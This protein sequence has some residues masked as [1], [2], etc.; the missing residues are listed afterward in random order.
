MNILDIC[1]DGVKHIYN[2]IYPDPYI[3]IA[4]TFANLLQ[5]RTPGNTEKCIQHIDQYPKYYNSY[6]KNEY[7]EYNPVIVACI[8]NNID[9]VTKLLGKKI[10]LNAKSTFSGRAALH[11][12]CQDLYTDIAL[13]LIR[14]G[15]D[16]NITDS[17]DS[18]PLHYSCQV[19][20]EYIAIELIQHGADVNMVNQARYTPFEIACRN[21][22]E[23]LAIYMM[24]HGAKFYDYIDNPDINKCTKVQQYIYDKYRA[25]LISVINDVNDNPLKLSFQTTYAIGIIDIIC[26]FIISVKKLKN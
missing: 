16:V 6:Y 25:G 11:I 19:A 1:I 22:V 4:Q 10:F 23:S 17:Y 7:T 24:D 2:K 14:A 12:A 21:N 18:T 8:W 26:D 9:V 5:K 20:V 15:A 3:E 13:K